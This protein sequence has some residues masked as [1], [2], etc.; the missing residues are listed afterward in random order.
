MWPGSL[1]SPPSPFSN[2]RCAFEGS[3]RLQPGRLEEEETFE[4][5]SQQPQVDAQ[6]IGAL[7]WGTLY[8]TLHPYKDVI[9]HTTSHRRIDLRQTQ[10]SMQITRT[11]RPHL[12]SSYQ[13]YVTT[14]VT[15]TR[16]SGDNN[17]DNVIVTSHFGWGQTKDEAR[18]AAADKLLVVVIQYNNRMAPKD[19][20]ETCLQLMEEKRAQKKALKK[21]ASP[22]RLNLIQW[23]IYEVFPTEECDPHG[24]HFWSMKPDSEPLAYSLGEKGEKF[25]I[26]QVWNSKRKTFL[27]QTHGHNIADQLYQLRESL[28]SRRGLLRG[29]PNFVSTQPVGGDACTPDHPLPQMP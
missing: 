6:E 11:L 8:T 22:K 26:K 20:I 9:P 13:W 14:M 3:S 2:N 27:Y 19:L 16:P 10:R 17:D 21:Q 7:S 4:G 25:L 18:N 24:V 23:L 1:L 12:A 28:H 15:F 29:A 5:Q